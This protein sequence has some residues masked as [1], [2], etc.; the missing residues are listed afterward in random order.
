MHKATGDEH[1]ADFAV[2]GFR[3]K[4]SFIEKKSCIVVGSYDIKDISKVRDFGN[5]VF[6]DDK[7]LVQI[8]IC[9]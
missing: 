1:N 3:A 9:I 6:S 7:G 4:T 5:L 2:K 8:K